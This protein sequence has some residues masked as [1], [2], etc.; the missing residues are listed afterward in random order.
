LLVSFSILFILIAF[1]AVKNQLGYKSRASGSECVPLTSEDN[2]TQNSKCKWTD[3]LCNDKCLYNTTQNICISRSDCE[4]KDSVC[5]DKMNIESSEEDSKCLAKNGECQFV[6]TPSSTIFCTY[7][8]KYKGE[9]LIEPLCKDS[10]NRK[11]CVPFQGGPCTEVKDKEGCEMRYF[12]LW[13]DNTCKSKEPSS[14]EENKF[15]NDCKN[16]KRWSC[17]WVEKDKKC[18]ISCPSTTENK[19]KCE[20]QY[21]PYSPYCYWNNK[22]KECIFR[23]QY[24]TS[25]PTCKNYKHCRWYKNVCLHSCSIYTSLSGCNSRSYCKWVGSPTKGSCTDTK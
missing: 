15:E 6:A 23:C 21:M 19:D 1:V 17:T 9:Y 24:N 8:E 2:C 12:C 14:C 5:I 7:K 11:C 18:I 25:E 13:E 22:T 20:S 4:W 3:N 16:F 10:S